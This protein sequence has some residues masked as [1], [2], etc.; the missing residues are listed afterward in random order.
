MDGLIAL[1]LAK[2]YADSVGQSIISAGFRVQVEQDRSILETTGEEKV[3]Y[4]LPKASSNLSIDDGYDEFVYANNKWEW[5]GKTDVDLSQYALKNEIPTKVSQLQ[6][7]SGFLTEYQDIS[8][9]ADKATTLAGYGIT[10]GQTKIDSTYKL[11]SDLVDDTNKTNKFVTSSEK[12]TWNGKYEKPGGG[13][14]K[15]DLASAVQ[16]SIDKADGALQMPSGGTAGQVL[17]KTASDTEWKDIPKEY[18][19]VNEIPQNAD[20]SQKYVLP[21]GYIYEW[22]EGSPSIPSNYNTK[23]INQ[24]PGTHGTDKDYL[25]TESGVLCSSL[26]P[27]DA[28][29]K[30][31]SDSTYG[32]L[33]NIQISGISELL[34]TYYDSSIIVYYYKRED[35][36]FIGAQRTANI[37]TLNDAPLGSSISLPVQFSLMDR[38]VYFSGM[39]ISNPGATI[40]YVR[41]LLGVSTSG[42]ISENDIKDVMIN[43]P[44]YDTPATSDGW[45]NTGVKHP[46]YLKD[47][48]FDVSTDQVLYAVGDSITYGYGVGGNNYSWVKHVI[49]HNGYAA[50]GGD[51]SKNLGENNLGFCTNS[52]S[53]FGN[54][55]I[56][57]VVDG[58][59]FAGADIVTVA[60]GINDWKNANAT[61]ANFWSGMQYCFNKIRSDNP[62]CK[63]YYILPF[64]VSFAGSY[65]TFYG[66]G[67]KGDSDTTKCYAYKLQEF[68][69]LIKEKFEEASFKAYR[70]ELIDMTECAAINRQ[71]ITTALI[72]NRSSGGSDYGLHPTAATHAVL[73]KEIARILA[74]R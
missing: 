39:D 43:V 28:S 38:E 50:Y 12:T 51:G 55:S 34:P 27:F 18:E 59:N 30:Y 31:D 48:I 7:D 53:S 54:H 69:N 5:V 46:Y 52:T 42:A 63:I 66:L 58:I 62:Y 56:Q 68:I 44:F 9:K 74:Q 23:L 6:N 41:V 70:V 22:Q 14:P 8:G 61:L 29:W 49:D 21:D 37:Y 2:K 47:S 72:D 16:T 65:S 11:S 64:N 4:L 25:T 10:D 32:S 36:S 71:N 24:R 19:F 35:G 13:I 1:A 67:F 73:G 40:G 60:L 33:A 26:I 20:H 17:T 57:D 3:L 15:T 45:V